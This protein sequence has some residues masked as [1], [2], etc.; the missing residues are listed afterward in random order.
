MNSK[1]TIRKSG[2][3]WALKTGHKRQLSKKQLAVIDDMLDGQFDEQTVLARQKV[4]RGLYRK[5]LADEHFIAEFDRRIAWLGRHGR[6]LIAN[7]T[8]LAAAKLVE[9]S[10]CDKEETARKACL[11]IIT[12]SASADKTA[13]QPS[14]SQPVDR[15]VSG[16]SDTTASRLLAAL[17]ETK[18]EIEKT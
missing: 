14:E 15:A 5:W 6:A 3:A 18:D 17:A 9:L 16:L 4:S 11:D 13:E 12:M 1:H 8:R 7:Y 10:N 2:K